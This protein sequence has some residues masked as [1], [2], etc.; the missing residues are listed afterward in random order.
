MIRVL[1]S[2]EAAVPSWFP[3]DSRVAECLAR[4]QVI[5]RFR[6][7]KY[8]IRLLKDLAALLPAGKARVLDIGT[9]SGLISEAISEFL[10][11]KSVVGVDVA[12]RVLPRMRLSFVAYDGVN[13]P[14]ID[15]SFDCSLLCNVLHHVDPEKRTRLMQE[16]LRVTGGGPVIIKDHVARSGWDRLR[17]GALDAAG[18]L[19]FSGMVRAEYLS[20]GDWETLLVQ[21]GCTG[22]MLPVSTYRSGLSALCFPNRLEICFSVRAVSK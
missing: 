8:Q 4:H 13:L 14:F 18:N 21:L 1:P 10:P 6:A 16:A 11:G 9:G 2:E 15:G 17:L 5:Y 20:D 3:S 7:P 22:A 12:P 19:P